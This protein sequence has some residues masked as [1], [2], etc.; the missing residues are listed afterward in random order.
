MLDEIS[1]RILTILQEDG[2]ISS[3]ELSRR[4]DLAQSTVY[5]R[6]RE[7]ERQGVIAGYSARLDPARLG[8]GLVA[9]VLVRGG[10]RREAIETGRRLAK[11]PRVQ[12]VHQVAGEDSLLVKVRAR[13]NG[14]LWREFHA[15]LERIGPAGEPRTLIV[16]ETF[17][18]STSLDPDGGTPEEEP[19]AR[20]PR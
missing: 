4:L 3:A 12:E 6:V 19:E 20:E 8:Q 9:F 13:D 5:E 16:L 1:R 10:S 11:L 17:K 14:E 18:E 15:E 2:R 7:L